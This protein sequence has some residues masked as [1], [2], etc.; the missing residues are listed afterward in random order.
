MSADFLPLFLVS[1]RSP[2]IVNEAG[3]EATSQLGPYIE[4]STVEVSCE[5]S[6]GESCVTVFPLAGQCAGHLLP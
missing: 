3:R 2:V 1:P 5:V 4:A 6:G